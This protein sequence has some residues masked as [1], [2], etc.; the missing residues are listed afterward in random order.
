MAEDGNAVLLWGWLAAVCVA[1]ITAKT[2]P[3]HAWEA[4]DGVRTPEKWHD[5]DVGVL[6]LLHLLDAVLLMKGV[7]DN[8]DEIARQR[9]AKG[10][11]VDAE[12]RGGGRQHIQDGVRNLLNQ[13][14]SLILLSCLLIRLAGSILGFL[15]SL[16]SSRP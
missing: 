16:K 7:V 5:L 1:A 9:A 10:I 13:F 4:Y 8:G 3:A 6:L 12:G 14:L 11:M 2:R 15:C